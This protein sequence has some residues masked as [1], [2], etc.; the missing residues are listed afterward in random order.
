MIFSAEKNFNFLIPLLFLFPLFKE[1]ISTFLF[2]LLAANTLYFALKN[3]SCYL[4]KSFL[5]LTIPFWIILV[6]CLIWY[7]K[8]ED[9]KPVENSLFF[10][11]FPIVLLNIPKSFFSKEKL[12]LYFEIL[13]YVCAIVCVGY[14]IA[15]FFYY[16][17][18]QLFQYQY[19]IP[20]FRDFIYNEI[21][22]F[23][24]HPTYF[25]SVL[26][27]VSAYSLLNL[28][29]NKKWSELV[30]LIIFTITSTALLAKFN[31]VFLF[32]TILYIVLFK[33]SMSKKIALIVSLIIILFSVSAFQFIPGVKNR[34]IEVYE[35]YNKPPEGMAFDSTNIRIAI[36]NCSN[37]ILKDN[38]LTG[39]GFQNTKEVLLDCFK[40]NYNSEFYN[41]KEYLTHNYF[42]Y[43]LIS[44][45]VFGLLFYLIYVITIVRYAFKV[46][47]FLLNIVLL[48]VLCVCFIE[49]YFFRQF[50]L[51]YFSL[52]FYV[53]LNNKKEEIS[54]HNLKI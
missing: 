23:K 28:T 52:M 11:F 32:L 3:K 13:K 22:F 50:G 26:V 35:S 16:D 25:T 4:N 53:F 6:T 1:N 5:L 49:D 14:F 33:S 10:L 29:E 7:S 47:S 40:S 48:N 2:I 46:N 41:E 8:K 36:V 24:I 45:G 18:E 54:N 51:Y 21:S 37:E 12:N 44:S 27:F 38:Y 17:Y 42:M 31:I 30:F 15:F 34:F 19:N 20:K 39:V 9:L 43:I